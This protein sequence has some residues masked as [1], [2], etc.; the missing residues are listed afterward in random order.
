MDKIPFSAYDFFGY[1]APGMLV[2]AGLE[3]TI[4]YPHILNQDLKLFAIAVLVLAVYV[5][6]HLMAGPAE[7]VLEDWFAT[8]ALGRPSENLFASKGAHPI[9]A[10]LF[11]SYFTPLQSAVQARVRERA[12]RAGVEEIGEPLFLL[13]R[14]HE[15]TLANERLLTKLDTFVGRYGFARNM[16]FT[17]MLFATFLLG[18]VAVGRGALRD[19][20]R[21]ALLMTAGVLL[22]YRYLKFYRQYSFELFSNYGSYK[23]SP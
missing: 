17:C 23:E 3:W 4:G 19:G 6:G 21:A 5:A 15:Q 11:P 13:V 12:R 22:L 14:F 16:A 8:K 9:L 20:T 10:R 2:L 7:A 18:K 1:V